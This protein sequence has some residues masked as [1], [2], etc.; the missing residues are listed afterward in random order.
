M[1]NE[2]GKAVV[3]LLIILLVLLIMIAGVAFA[4]TMYFV[5]KEVN[6]V[7]VVDV[8]V[9]YNKITLSKE[10]ESK[11]MTMM[12]YSEYIQPSET[13]EISDGSLVFAGIFLAW[14]NGDCNEKESIQHIKKEVFEKNVYE[15]FGQTIKE[16]EKFEGGEIAFKNNEYIIGAFG[17]DGPTYEYEI[18]NVYDLKDGN[19]KIEFLSTATAVVGDDAG[20]IEGMQRISCVFKKVSESKWGY[21]YISCERMTPE[22]T[23]EGV[24]YTVTKKDDHHAVITATKGVNTY[25]KEIETVAMIDKVEVV[26]LLEDGKVVTISDTGGEYYGIKVYRLIN[27]QIIRVGE[28]YPGEVL[29]D[30]TYN[31]VEREAGLATIEAVS[32]GKTY[33]KEV[34]E[35]VKVSK[36]IMNFGTSID[37]VVLQVADGDTDNIYIYILTTADGEKVIKRVGFIDPTI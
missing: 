23:R 35:Y 29:K 21:N 15:F 6:V 17:L 12:R 14:E 25:T 16:P 27:G 24:E 34:Y 11:I 30:V 26:E 32:D 4:A 18:L 31:V 36:N 10:E 13:G 28:I 9:K 19:I 5:K 8:E 20:S 37:F 7:D 33:K 22:Y 1:K 3:V 2:K